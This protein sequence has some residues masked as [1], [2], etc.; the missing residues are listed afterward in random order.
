MIDNTKTFYFNGQPVRTVTD[1]NG[2]VWFVAEDVTNIMGYEDSDKA[3][4][5]HCREAKTLGEI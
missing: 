4:K 3:V 1:D 2:K 5:E